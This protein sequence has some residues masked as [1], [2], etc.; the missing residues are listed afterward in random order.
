VRAVCGVVVLLAR[1]RHVLRAA[2]LSFLSCP[3]PAAPAPAGTGTAKGLRAQGKARRRDERGNTHNAQRTGVCMRCV[4]SVVVPVCVAARSCAAGLLLLF[5]GVCPA[6]VPLCRG[7]SCSRD[8]APAHGHTGNGCSVS[9][10]TPTCVKPRCLCV[11]SASPTASPVLGFFP[12]FAFFRLCPPP[13][14]SLCA[15]PVCAVLRA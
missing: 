8:S 11:A 13:S 12:L 10:R 3:L 7:P 15:V 6:A 2:A 14:G 1:G 9:R 4:C 5:V